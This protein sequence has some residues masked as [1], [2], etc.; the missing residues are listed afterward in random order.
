[1][2][3]IAAELDEK[4]RKEEEK[5]T[6]RR[7]VGLFLAVMNHANCSQI[8]R[9]AEGGQGANCPTASRSMRPHSTQCFKVWGSHIVGQ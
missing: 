2:E 9:A 3:K 8:S 5:E 7:Q 6:A 1:M 4:K